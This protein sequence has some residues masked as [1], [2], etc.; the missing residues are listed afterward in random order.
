M[1][2]WLL[3][4]LWVGQTPAI[5]YREFSSEARC[6][7]AVRVITAEAGFNRKLAYCVPQ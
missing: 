7:E 3:I 6:L 2:T 4:V 5:S 1:M